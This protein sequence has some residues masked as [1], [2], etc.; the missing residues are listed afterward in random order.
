MELIQELKERGLVEH[1][2]ADI[3]KIFSK[4]RTIY[5]GVDPSADSMQ[6]GNLL[7]VLMMKRFA[8]AGHKIILLVGGG[9]G[10]IGDPREKG[11]R[12]LQD[13]KVIEKNKKLIRAQMQEI[14]GSRVMLVDNADWLLKIKMFEFL[15]DIG[16]HFTVNE[17]I[18]RVTSSSAASRPPT[19]AFHTR[20]SRTRFFRHT[21][22]WF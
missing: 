13:I 8:D 22:T 9:T 18:K 20:S 3:D 2:S 11:E 1:S 15:R 21:T 14:I 10:M 12:Q 7:V 17:L 4:K 5:L 6:A 19:K 16:K